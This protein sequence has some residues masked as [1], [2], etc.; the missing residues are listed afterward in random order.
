MK[1]FYF[2]IKNFN[3]NIVLNFDQKTL[4][5][6]NANTEVINCLLKQPSLF[7]SSEETQIKISS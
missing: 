5:T 4:K 1:K 3:K 2:K 6:L 7:E